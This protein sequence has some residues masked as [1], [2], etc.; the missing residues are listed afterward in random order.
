MVMLFGLSLTIDLFACKEEHMIY[1][2]FID[3]ACFIDNA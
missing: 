2:V 1:L 3:N